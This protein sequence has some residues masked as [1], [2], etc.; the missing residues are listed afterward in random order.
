MP[1][2]V[3][4]ISA[5]GLVL[6][7]V[8]LLRIRGRRKT[9]GTAIV[10]AALGL[11]AVPAGESAQAAAPQPVTITKPEATIEPEIAA[12][13]K[14]LSDRTK[15]EKAV[16]ALVKQGQKSVAGLL[17]EA[18][19]GSDFVVQGWSIVALSRIG[20]K[21]IDN[22]LSALHSD[23]SRHALI[24]TWAAAARLN[25]ATDKDALLKLA[26]L[27]AT[28]PALGKPLA[29]KLAAFAG[30]D[31]TEALIKLAQQNPT[32]AQHIATVISGRGSDELA[33]VMVSAKDMNVRFLAAQ[34]LGGQPDAATATI[35]VYAFSLDTDI[36]PWDGGPLY[37]PGIQWK[38]EDGEKLVTNLLKWGVWCERAGKSTEIQ[39]ISNNLNSIQLARNVGYEMNWNTRDMVGWLKIWGKAKGKAVV[40]EILKANKAETDDRYKGVLDGLK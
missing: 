23:S 29:K 30:A 10:I 27:C 7:L 1:W 14:D 26:P 20:G 5:G 38:K 24:R 33:K 21:D 19:Y 34:Y 3:W 17:K 40:E 31:S 12:L 2:W 15:A 6:V 22:S 25:M 37:V 32:I 36:A 39:Q 16:E 35:N 28:M 11:L 13:I 9:G 4:A 8:V 18:F